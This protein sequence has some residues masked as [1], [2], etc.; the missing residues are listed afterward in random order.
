MQEE[1]SGVVTTAMLRDAEQ[2]VGLEF[3]EEEREGMVQAVN[4]NLDRFE[5]MREIS[6]ANSDWPSCQ[7]DPAPG[8]NWEGEQ[9]EIRWSREE[10]RR[11]ADLEEVAFWPVSRLSRLIQTGQVSSGE[12]TRM[13][14]GRLKRYGPTLE[15]VV[16]LTEDLARRQAQQADREIGMGRI[17]GPLHGIPWGV[18][19]LM[20]TKEYPTTWGAAPYRDQQFDVDATVVQRL[21]EAGAVLVAK[22][23][24]GELAAGDIWFGG[25]VKNPWNLQEGTRG[26]SAGPGAATAA[27]LVGFSL[28]TETRGSIIFPSTR[29]G[30]TGLRPTFGR[31]SRYGVMAISFSMDK[32]GPMCRSVEDCA[33]VFEAIRGPDGRDG[34]LKDAPFNWDSERDVRGLKVGYVESAFLSDERESPGWKANDEAMLDKLRELGIN[35]IPVEFPRYDLDVQRIML[36]SEGAAAFD[37]LIR[38]RRDRLLSNPNLWPRWFR[39][40]RFIPAVEYIQ[41][42]RIRTRLVGE[43]NELLSRVDMILVPPSAPGTPLNS[44]L[45]TNTPL[46]NLTGHPSVVFPN[47][48]SERGTP[49]TVTAVGKLFA[50]EEILALAHLVRYLDCSGDPA[51]QKNGNLYRDRIVKGRWMW[52]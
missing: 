15:C 23:A 28:G 8:V 43:M 51:C 9:R 35:L 38:S 27:G 32:A 48:F 21:E 6:L 1:G 22:L 49:T 29:C 52:S 18:K 41:A 47:G 13:Y 2:M 36:Y 3:T 39:L 24:T 44:P 42:D 26:S 17:R 31:V 33:M 16:T 30:L 11:P 34:T 50:E 4:Q 37:E 19:D 46:T 5:R 20:A 10:V 40:S 14:L 7:F 12:L 25:A 45:G